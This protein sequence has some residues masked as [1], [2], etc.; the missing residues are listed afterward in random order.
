MAMTLLSSIVLRGEMYSR[1]R[2]HVVSGW[3]K[4]L[5][6]YGLSFP[7]FVWQ[8]PVLDAQAQ[9]SEHKKKRYSYARGRPKTAW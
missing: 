1:L 6:N 9:S 7:G 4:V 8:V 5:A 2:D 3:P